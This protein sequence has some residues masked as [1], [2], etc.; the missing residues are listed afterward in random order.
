MFGIKTR[1]YIE[2]HPGTNLSMVMSAI[3]NKETKKAIR[4]EIEYV[5]V[6]INTKVPFVEFYIREIHPEL[7][8][9]T[10]IF[11]I[12]VYEDSIK[13]TDVSVDVGDVV[14]IRNVLKKHPE[15]MSWTTVES[16]VLH[17][18]QEAVD[19]IKYIYDNMCPFVNIKREKTKAGSIR[20]KLIISLLLLI[21]FGFAIAVFV[22]AI[23][24][25]N[26]FSIL[27]FIIAALMYR[28]KSRKEEKKLVSKYKDR[29]IQID[30]GEA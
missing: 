28:H 11:I 26:V 16:K 5:D 15:I 8:D 24:M 25:L 6:Y 20:D 12:R 14:P 17:N 1:K 21:V 23:L 22:I 4:D 30:M 27:V 13:Y 10:K 19:F 3:L 2:A 9:A 18:E 7:T 29:F